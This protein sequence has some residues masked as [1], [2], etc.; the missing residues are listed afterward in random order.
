MKTAAAKI[1]RTSFFYGNIT[2]KQVAKYLSILPLIS[3]FYLS[4]E[5]FKVLSPNENVA[6][7]QSTPVLPTFSF[8]VQFLFFRKLLCIGFQIFCNVFV[9]SITRMELFSPNLSFCLHPPPKLSEAGLHAQFCLTS[10]SF[11][12]PWISLYFS[13]LSLSWLSR[14]F[15]QPRRL[16][17]KGLQWGAS[18]CFHS[19]P[20]KCWSGLV[21]WWV[22][23]PAEGSSWPFGTMALTPLL[24]LLP[25][26]DL[27]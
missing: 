9:L 1:L 22:Q 26:K 3:H 24:L 14:F 21:R 15:F 27:S 2:K 4:S 18:L 7:C 17:L 19:Y 12:F 25:Q 13:P 11:L 6:V 23:N 16:C 20:F 10:V 5:S 8:V